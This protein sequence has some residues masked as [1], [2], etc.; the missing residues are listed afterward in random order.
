ML[1][2]GSALYTGAL[3]GW[4]Y[5]YLKQANLERIASNYFRNITV[6]YIVGV[7]SASIVAGKLYEHSFRLPFMLSFVF[8][9]INIFVVALIHFEGKQENKS[10]QIK[11]TNKFVTSIKKVGIIFIKSREIF[12]FTVIMCLVEFGFDGI[13]RYY[14]IILQNKHISYFGISNVYTGI[15]II[16]ILILLLRNKILEKDI[17]QCFCIE[18]G[19]LG[20]FVGTFFMLISDGWVAYFMIVFSLGSYEIIAPA[21]LAYLNSKFDDSIRATSLSIFEFVVSI[22]EVLSGVIVGV[23]CDLYGVHRAIEICIMVVFVVTLVFACL[24]QD[25]VKSLKY[26]L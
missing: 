18:L 1:G 2:I 3:D 19:M 11:T 9:A 22:F 13:E 4:L 12:A 6:L 16:S 23:I 14:Q 24:N 10:I 26:K 8:S 7:G 17:Y 21:K 15:T 5:E 25:V 20:I